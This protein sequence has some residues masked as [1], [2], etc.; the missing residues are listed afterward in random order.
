MKWLLSFIYG[1]FVIWTGLLRGIEAGQYKPNSLW[2][3]LVMGLGCISSGYWFRLRKEPLGLAVGVFASGVVLLFYL[4]CFIN[5][6]ESDATV[7][8]GL[9]IVA[10]IGYLALICLPSAPR[11]T[12]GEQ[13]LI[14][15]VQPP[16]GPS[17][18]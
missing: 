16:H 4:Y 7:R 1:L 13:K 12:N 8:V 3:C 5:K 6:P 17:D 14:E 11:V 2:F 18:Y 9:V 10:S 15:P